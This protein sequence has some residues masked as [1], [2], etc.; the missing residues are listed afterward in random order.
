[1]PPRVWILFEQPATRKQAFNFPTDG[2]HAAR[3]TLL[4]KPFDSDPRRLSK[5]LAPPPGSRLAIDAPNS[6]PL[7]CDVQKY[8]AEK[9]GRFAFIL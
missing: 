5:G 8:K 3:R 9:H 7:G 6:R 2:Q 1:M 4:V